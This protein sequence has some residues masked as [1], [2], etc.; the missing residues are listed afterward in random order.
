MAKNNYDEKILIALAIILI[1]PEVGFTWFSV[2]A[3]LNA[4][5][6]SG[7]TFADDES[8]SSLPPVM[9]AAWVIA[10]LDTLTTMLSIG[11]PRKAIKESI[12]ELYE[13]FKLKLVTI[14]TWQRRKDYQLIKETKTNSTAFNLFL[15]LHYSLILT[16]FAISVMTVA[17][18]FLR[19]FGKTPWGIGLAC[20]AY[21]G[22]FALLLMQTR[23]RIPN[24]A[25]N[26]AD[27]V[28]NIFTFGLY[29][30]GLGSFFKSLGF[31]FWLVRTIC[32]LINRALRSFAIGDQT[33][34]FLNINFIKNEKD[35]EISR[36]FG[37]INAFCII[38]YIMCT[39]CRDDLKST[40]KKNQQTENSNEK[41]IQPSFWKLNIITKFL[42][43]GAWSTFVLA[44][45]AFAYTLW[46]G[47]Y[48]S[49]HF[50]KDAGIFAWSLFPILALAAWQY[51]LFV[52]KQV[53]EGVSTLGHGLYN[54][55]DWILPSCIMT[56][57]EKCASY[58]GSQA[59]NVASYITAPCSYFCH[60]ATKEKEL[61]EPKTVS[62]NEL[63]PP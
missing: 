29:N 22:A 26:L 15:G 27:F 60:E 43:T 8:V 4:I 30:K 36:I 1:L 45:I 38:Y 48:D 18:G 5:G 9:Y 21:G 42:I 37:Y 51:T 23:N 40:W 10:S 54:L 58:V 24:S 55:V 41:D 56:P 57:L 61:F 19:W 62:H 6:I 50:N 46:D 11:D 59:S 2:R 12:G 20:Y 13:Y 16:A 47:Q 53:D 63:P 52:R 7:Q 31:W 3:I 28:K 39:Q 44:G 25:A 35:D 17:Q 14:F 32:N 33:G 34:H 49:Q